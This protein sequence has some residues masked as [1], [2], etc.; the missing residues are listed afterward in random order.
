M[1]WIASVIFKMLG[2]LPEKIYDEISSHF[3]KERR[4]KNEFMKI[5]TFM[6]QSPLEADMNEGIKKLWEFF[7]ENYQLYDKPEVSNFVDK[8]IK[9]NPAAI[10]LG[11]RLTGNW[12]NEKRAEMLS[13]LEK[14]KPLI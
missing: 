2:F 13:D 9:T 14:I 11:G 10:D 6:R 3:A 8:W 7:N 12:T 1:I 5:Y 4:L